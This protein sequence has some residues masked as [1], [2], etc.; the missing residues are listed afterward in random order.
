MLSSVPSHGQDINMEQLEDYCNNLS[1]DD[2][3][4]LKRRQEN[5][6][7]ICTKA[8]ENK[9]RQIE[10][11]GFPQFEQL[12]HDVK[13]EIL[14]H[15]SIRS[16]RISKSIGS[17]T[18][19]LYMKKCFEPLTDREIKETGISA[20]KSALIVTILGNILVL[21]LKPL[22]F[23]NYQYVDNK[24]I[25]FHQELGFSSYTI[26]SGAMNLIDIE[27]V[28]FNRRGCISIDEN[29]VSKHL[30]NILNERYNKD[31]KEYVFCNLIFNLVCLKSIPE[32]NI[33]DYTQKDIPLLYKMLK[34]RLRI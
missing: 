21:S 15:E 29:Y 19:D 1:T 31:N 10:A 12:P 5:I 33:N 14:K 34:Q 28:L 6:Y 13:R 7:E 4:K 27:S 32:K 24:F 18:G 22:G 3:R 23:K 11:E 17:L 16:R 26:L 20:E 8:L 30:S 2:L 9:Y 25:P